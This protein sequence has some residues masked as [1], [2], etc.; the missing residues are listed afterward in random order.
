MSSIE[1]I[2][3]IWR[4]AS[5]EAGAASVAEIAAALCDLTEV[6]RWLQACEIRLNQR[7]HEVSTDGGQGVDPDA[8]NA[9][10]TGRSLADAARATRRARAASQLPALASA[11]A[12]GRLS[13][14]HLDAFASAVASLPAGLRAH[15]R[16]SESRLVAE[17]MSAG[18]TP[19]A[20]RDRLRAESRRLVGDDGHSRIG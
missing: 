20:F 5:F 1:V 6:Q 11:I 14:E 10:A 12:A 7:L 3:R 19:E 18:L 4:L 17:A 8:V 2:D 13:A 16:S 15:L 9:R